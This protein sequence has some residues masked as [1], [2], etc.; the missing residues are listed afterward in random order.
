MRLPFER[1]GHLVTVPVSANG[2]ETRFVLDT[3]IGLT[4]LTSALCERLGCAHTGAVFSGRRMSGQVVTAP[5]VRLGSLRFG[6]LER[7]DLDVGVFDSSGFAAE[8]AEIGGFLSLSFFGERPFTVD[9]LGNCV[10]LEQGR[11]LEERLRDGIAVEV[12]RE[13]EGPSLDVFMPFTIPG[14]DSISVEVD[15][16][17]DDLILDERFAET[18]GVD[19]AEPDV[20][21]EDGDDP[22]GDTFTRWF[23]TL[24]GCIHPANVPELA[25]ERPR[26]IFQRIVHDGLVGHAFLRR[27]PVTYDLAASRVIFGS[28]PD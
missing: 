9:Y 25:Q 6:D 20:R 10:V 13:E 2:V 1:I 12:V 3:G 11:G 5:L 19:L 21:R 7:R 28:L 17:S 14:A 8:F 4:L 15:M 18:A 26:V 24:P 27:Q 16:G 23:T 22:W